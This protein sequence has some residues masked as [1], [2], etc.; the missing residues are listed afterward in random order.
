M[1]GEVWAVRE[2]GGRGTAAA[3]E[4]HAR[5]ESPAVKAGGLGHAWSARRT[6]RSWP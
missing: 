1:W 3:H 6:C 2:A 5:G 4:H